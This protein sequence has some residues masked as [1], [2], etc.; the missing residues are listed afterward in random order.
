MD[1]RREEIQREWKK[2]KLLRENGNDRIDEKE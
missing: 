2:R 1:E